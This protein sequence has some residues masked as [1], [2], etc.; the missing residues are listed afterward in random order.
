MAETKALSFNQTLTALVKKTNAEVENLTQKGEL[1]L[2]PNYSAGN[3]L[4]QFQLMVQDDEKIKSCTSASIAKCM[5]DM[6]IMGLNP[7]KKQTY[8]IPYGNKA[9]LMPSY[10]GNVAIAKRIDPTIEDVRART[11]HRGEEFEFEDDMESGYSRVTKHKR[12]L[13]TM[14]VNN[15][16]EDIVGAYATIIYNDGKKPVSLVMPFSEVKKRWAKSQVHPIDGN[17][18]VKPNSTH[19]QFPDR[20]AE[21]TVI[22]AIC[23]PIIAKSDDNDLFTTTSQA[24]SIQAAKVEADAEAEEKMCSGDAIDVDFSEVEDSEENFSEPLDFTEPM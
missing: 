10:L 24:V 13:E 8:C 14:A 21:R 6:V 12:T 3:A 20:M 19:F 15:P 17:G 11:I 9:T 4:K 2:P 7:S 22:N 23:V 16:D 18:K 1:A 5:L